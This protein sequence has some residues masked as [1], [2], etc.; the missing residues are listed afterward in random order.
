MWFHVR[1][2]FFQKGGC[3]MRKSATFKLCFCGVMI[4]LST[5]LSLI[6]LWKMP[7]GGSVTLCSMLPIMLVGYFFDT[8]TGL[9]CAGVY[10]ILQAV[11][12]LGSISGWG[13]TAGVFAACILLD[14]LL[15]FTGLGFSG[16]FKDIAKRNGA[17]SVKK[18]IV[19]YICGM[20]FAVGLRFLCHFISGIVL[21]SSTAKFEPAWLY[22]LVYNGIYLLPDL[23]ICMVVGILLYKPLSALKAKA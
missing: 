10:S 2:L 18:D 20:A 23:A 12:S 22:S 16:I 6:T 5:V 1:F 21:W 15:A 4:A 11:L 17:L 3:F 7:F 8:K 9:A 14:Y 13:L 19:L